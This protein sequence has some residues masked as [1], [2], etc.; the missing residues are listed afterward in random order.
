[1]AVTYTDL[2]EGDSGRYTADGWQFTRIAIVTEITGTGHARIYNAAQ[3]LGV[4]IGASHP[5]VPTAYLMSVTPTSETSD[6]VKFRLDYAEYPF[7]DM[8]VS[9]GSTV[10]QIET[11]KDIN[12]DPFELEYAFP[13]DYHIDDYAGET[14]TT[15]A[16]VSLLSPETTMVV[17]K[18]I[19]GAD[20]LDVLVVSTSYVGKTNAAGWM[21]MGS[22]AE[23]TWLCTGIT[24]ETSDAGLTYMVT[25]SFHY[26]S[27]GWDSE[28]VFMDPNTGKPPSDVVEGV[29]IKTYQMYAQ[30]NFNNLGL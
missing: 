6:T 2:I 1:M 18:H 7:A 29:G 26:R 21:V 11:N 10:S 3:Q 14:I 17:R 24:G 28:I 19:T 4:F 25:Y 20:Y 22:P 5:T 16:V 9:I 12:G 30:A 8:Q 23:N 15:G 27:D 13:A